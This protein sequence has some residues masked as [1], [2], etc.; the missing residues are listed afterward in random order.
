MKNKLI[1]I[2]IMA[3]LFIACAIIFKGEVSLPELISYFVG[4]SGAISAVASWIEKKDA[5]AEKEEEIQ[6]LKRER[7]IYKFRAD[8]LA[9]KNE[10]NSQRK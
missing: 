9:K 7:S 2:G 8:N 1:F 10:I 6:A 3:A 5:I 4:A